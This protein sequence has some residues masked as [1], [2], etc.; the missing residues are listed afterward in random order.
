ML[1]IAYINI[2]TFSYIHKLHQVTFLLIL[3]A[4]SYFCSYIAENTHLILQ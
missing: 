2:T 3:I 4:A 1:L